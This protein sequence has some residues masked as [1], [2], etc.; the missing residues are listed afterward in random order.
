[1][2]HYLSL[3]KEQTADG[4]MQYMWYSQQVE[5]QKHEQVEPR[6]DAVLMVKY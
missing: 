3:R 1:M 6:T 4:V 2:I 5:S